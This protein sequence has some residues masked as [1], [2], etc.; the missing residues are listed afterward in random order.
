MSSPIITLVLRTSDLTADEDNDVGYANTYKTSM[1]WRN[2]NFK[3]VLGR[4]FDEY[5][6][7]KIV[8][9]QYAY[10]STSTYGVALVDNSPAL[11]ISGLP[12]INYYE[13]ARG[14]STGGSAIIKYLSFDEGLFAVVSE[15]GIENGLTFGSFGGNGIRD[16]TL[17]YI[18]L[19][20]VNTEIA[21]AEIFPE[22]AF[23]FTIYPVHKKVDQHI[24]HLN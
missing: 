12:F 21:T 7:F 17:S 15:S 10:H 19:D 18:L 8:L 2:I 16:I 1:T 9:S 22:V 14:H 24:K 3:N 5:D 23:L 11:R 13:S 4:Y 20:T 6:E